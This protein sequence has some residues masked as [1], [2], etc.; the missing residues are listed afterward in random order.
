MP[1]MRKGFLRQTRTAT[2]IKVSS[3]RGGLI[4]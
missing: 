4:R 3:V 1:G 2:G